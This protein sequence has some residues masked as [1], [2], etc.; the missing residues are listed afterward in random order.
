[1]MKNQRLDKIGS[2]WRTEIPSK[3]FGQPIPAKELLTV[4]PKY[5]TGV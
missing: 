4:P 3:H 5:K 1:M 2:T